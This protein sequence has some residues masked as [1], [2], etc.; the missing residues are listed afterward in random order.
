MNR[1]R[2]LTALGL[3]I[4]ASIAIGGW[5]LLSDPISG[6]QSLEVNEINESDA[7]ETIIE[8]DNLSNKQQNVFVRAVESRDNI[9]TIPDD[10]NASVWG[11]NYGVRYKGSIYR[12]VVIVS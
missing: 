11:S 2:I 7:N 3:V 9:A 12:T 1:N 10:V 8:Y 5:Y 6:G 4:L